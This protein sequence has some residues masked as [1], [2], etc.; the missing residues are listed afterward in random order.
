MIFYSVGTQMPFDRLYGYLS[1]WSRHHPDVDI[2]AQTGNRDGSDG[3]I[4]C[5]KRLAEPLF[6]QHFDNASIVVSH[7]G[8]GNIIRSLEL[9]K[10]IVIVPRDSTQGEHINNHQFDTVENFSSFSSV[11]IARNQEEFLRAMDTAQQFGNSEHKI[12]FS[13]RNKLISYLKDFVA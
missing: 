11:F 7:A 6:S 4:K 8:M 5:F 12:K 3:K 13:E 9:S 1:E 10:P 2:V